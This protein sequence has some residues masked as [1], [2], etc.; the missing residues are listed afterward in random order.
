MPKITN[1][2]KTDEEIQTID[3]QRRRL[4]IASLQG[5][6]KAS[7]H[8]L[9]YANKVCAEASSSYEDPTK[10]DAHLYS[11]IEAIFTALSEVRDHSEIGQALCSK[12]V[13]DKTVP[14]LEKFSATMRSENGIS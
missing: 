11:C 13:G 7:M 9:D 6:I 5:K 10:S 3:D 8:L 2:P 1:D 14:A 12:I 4:G